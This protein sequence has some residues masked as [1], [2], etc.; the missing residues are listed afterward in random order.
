MPSNHDLERDNDQ[1]NQGGR[2]ETDVR[3]WRMLPSQRRP[4]RWRVV[5]IKGEGLCPFWQFF[6]KFKHEDPKEYIRLKVAL[7]KMA[8]YGPSKRCHRAEH[9]TK[10]HEILVYPMKSGDMYW[11][12]GNRV[13]V[14]GETVV[15]RKSSMVISHVSTQSSPEVRQLQTEK[16]IR[17]RETLGKALQISSFEDLCDDHP[18]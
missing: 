8:D 16:A 18:W 11:F 5:A 7:S 10:H 9:S 14:N 6:E 4:T 17:H 13:R 15:G 12:H 3:L 1:R 2:T